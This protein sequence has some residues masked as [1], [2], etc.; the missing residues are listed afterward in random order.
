MQLGQDSYLKLL[1]HLAHIRE[2]LQAPSNFCD[3]SYYNDSS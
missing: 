1:H 3:L 2:S